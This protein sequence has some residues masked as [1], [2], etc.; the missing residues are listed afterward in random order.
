MPT[1]WSFFSSSLILMVFRGLRMYSL[2]FTPLY[3]RKARKTLSNFCDA[4]HRRPR[5]WEKDFHITASSAAAAR[6]ELDASYCDLSCKTLFYRSR[7]SKTVVATDKL[8]N[9]F[10]PI[11]WICI[12]LI[13][14]MGSHSFLSLINCYSHDSINILAFIT[15]PKRYCWQC[16]FDIGIGKPILFSQL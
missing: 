4:S 14:P 15:I 16:C 3:I 8:V 10:E 2:R 9:T 7:E 1:S 5:I 6:F 12:C 11:G 13:C